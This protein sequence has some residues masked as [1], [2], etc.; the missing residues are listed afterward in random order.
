M[1]SHS[2]AQRS[3]VLV[4]PTGLLAATALLVDT[5]KLLDSPG[6][7]ASGRAQRFFLKSCK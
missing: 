2:P 4:R 7:Q 5:L 6:P 3:L 1:P